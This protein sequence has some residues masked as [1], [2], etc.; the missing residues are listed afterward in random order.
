[1]QLSLLSHTVLVAKTAVLQCTYI[2]C[3]AYRLSKAVVIV[4]IVDQISI[5]ITVPFMV[6]FH[7][8]IPK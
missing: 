7:Y 2:H 8:C 6:L 5:V 4:H 1:M 3:G